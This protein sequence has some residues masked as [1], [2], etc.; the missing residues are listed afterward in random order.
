M[1]DERLL[2]NSFRV[3][4]LL[5]F[6]PMLLLA[7]ERQIEACPGVIT[8]ADMTSDPGLYAALLDR[9]AQ[10]RRRGSIQRHNIAPD[11]CRLAHIRGN[12]P[13]HEE[14]TDV[15]KIVL[16]RLERLSRAGTEVDCAKAPMNGANLTMLASNVAFAPFKRCEHKTS[17]REIKPFHLEITLHDSSH[18]LRQF[19]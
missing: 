1:I 3:Q 9:G 2:H 17:A 16:G 12:A 13:I 18:R 14:I 10:V 11:G 6:S 8:V 4:I 5:H 7:S 15:G 19:R